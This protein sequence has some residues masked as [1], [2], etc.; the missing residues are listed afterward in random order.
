MAHKYDEFDYFWNVDKFN[1]NQPYLLEPQKFLQYKLGFA[2]RCA[3]TCTT[4]SIK[5]T[6]ITIF[7][8][9][10]VIF[11]MG[12]YRLKQPESTTHNIAA[13]EKISRVP[14]LAK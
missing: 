3:N 11:E 14:K 9:S 2:W 7:R 13:L 8:A 10:I 1:I 5:Y 6:T 12:L 4:P